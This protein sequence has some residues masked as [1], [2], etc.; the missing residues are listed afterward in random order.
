MPRGGGLPGYG[1]F[2]GSMGYSPANTTL[3]DRINSCGCSSGSGGSSDE[4]FFGCLMTIAVAA[5]TILI[6]LILYS[7]YKYLLPLIR[8]II[9]FSH[10]GLNIILNLMPSHEFIIYILT[11]FLSI[12]CLL[13]LYLILASIVFDEGGSG[14]KRN[15]RVS[16]V[17]ACQHALDRA[18]AAR[19]VTDMQSLQKDGKPK[20]GSSE[21]FCTP[22]YE[23]ESSS[24]SSSI[25]SWFQSLPDWER[26]ITY[27]III[28]GVVSLLVVFVLRRCLG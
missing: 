10:R 3:R 5:N 13:F 16:D 9:Y 18:K 12:T 19:Y 17:I 22:R 28:G 14:N 24:I 23:F 21:Y 25:C 1:S 7:V 11:I 2:V 27:G 8:T 6:F 15:G 20:I 26:W 4:G